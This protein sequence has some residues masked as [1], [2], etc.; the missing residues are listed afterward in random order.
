MMPRFVV[1]ALILLGSPVLMSIIPVYIRGEGGYRKFG[2]WAWGLLP[3][4]G[5][6]TMKLELGAAAFWKE[7]LLRRQRCI[8]DASNLERSSE[9]LALLPSFHLSVQGIDFL[10]TVL[11]LGLSPAAQGSALGIHARVEREHV[12]WRQRPRPSP[13]AFGALAG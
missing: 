10:K 5:T 11:T 8:R 4:K 6:C 3:P 2:M 13:E 12:R 9:T 1:W 7:P